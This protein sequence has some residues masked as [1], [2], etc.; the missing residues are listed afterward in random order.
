[1]IPC[2]RCKGAKIFEQYLHIQ[3]G[4]C[5]RCR[6]TGIESAETDR[7]EKNLIKVSEPLNN[8]VKK[9][10]REN[11][12]EDWTAYCKMRYCNNL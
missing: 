11:Y 4:F 12:L 6:G 10:V 1:M 7:S 3:N 5:F 8:F 2:Q 9:F